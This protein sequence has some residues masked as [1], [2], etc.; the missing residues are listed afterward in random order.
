MSQPLSTLPSPRRIITYH[1]PSGESAAIEEIVPMKVFSALNSATMFIQEDFP[2]QP[3]KTV[4]YANAVSPTFTLSS[5]VTCYFVDFKPNHHGPL[6]F[7]NS[8]GESDMLEYI[9]ITHGSLHLEI[10]N[11]QSWTVS[12]GDAA[13]CVANAHYW[14]NKTNEWARQSF[15]IVP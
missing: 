9:V 7:A 2:A 8:V 6:H 4:E 12:Q 5:G 1:E 14:H 11:G 15:A 13:V 3:D 10:D